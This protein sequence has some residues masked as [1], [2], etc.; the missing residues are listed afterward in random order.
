MVVPT[1]KRKQRQAPDNSSQDFSNKKIKPPPAYGSIEYWNE[2]YLA[3]LCEARSNDQQKQEEDGPLPH[4]EWYFTY[5]ELRP[6]LIPLVLGGSAALLVEDEDAD[7]EIDQDN[8]QCDTNENPIIHAREN[9][10]DN[11]DDDASNQQDGDGEEFEE[12]EGSDSEQDDDEEDVALERTG[13]ISNGPIAILEVGCGDCPLAAAMALEVWNLS[14]EID[15]VSCDKAFRKIVCSDYSS[16]VIDVMKKQYVVDPQGGK[17]G[18]TDRTTID[19]AQIYV[20]DAPL[21]FETIDATKIPH[22]DKSFNMV[23][24]KGTMD[25]VLSDT[26]DGKQRSIQIMSECARVVSVGGSIVLISHLNAHFPA[27]LS[28]LEA[29]VFA[30]LKE[31]DTACNWEI[32][33]HGNNELPEGLEADDNVP[34]GATGPAVYIIS[35]LATGSEGKRKETIPVQF[36]SY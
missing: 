22:P 19:S 17:A 3:V 33:V 11:G 28:W 20:G 10:N 14:Q 9:E 31:G 21:S 34:P 12:V 23:L 4:H 35:K 7:G 32:E 2:R 24:E 29:V 13:L 27:G 5:K 6:L 26:K 8:P 18:A 30:G 16:V 25:A 1:K 15:T 36:F